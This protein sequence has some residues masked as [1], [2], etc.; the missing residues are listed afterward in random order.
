MLTG[1]RILLIVAGGI[2]AYKTLELIRR[3]RER[4]LSFRVILTRSGGGI[5]DAAEPRLPLREQGL[6]GAFFR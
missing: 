4:G 6:S 5:R 3:G 2:A 1:K